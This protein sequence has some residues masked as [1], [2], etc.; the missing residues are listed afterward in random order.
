MSGS[1]TGA[2]DMEAVNHASLTASLQH[3]IYHLQR[4]QRVGSVGFTQSL[5]S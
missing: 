2:S 1:E 5:N 3:I 4:A